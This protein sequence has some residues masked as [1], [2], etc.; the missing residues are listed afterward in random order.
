M[1]NRFRA[2]FA[3]KC[4][5]YRYITGWLYASMINFY[6]PWSCFPLFWLYGPEA[7]GQMGNGGGLYKLN[8]IPLNL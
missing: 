7:G 5:L 6:I 1:K 3:F 8:P 2:L 4:N